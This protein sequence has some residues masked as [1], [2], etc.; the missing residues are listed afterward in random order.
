MI[1]A[2]LG[3]LFLGGSSGLE[4]FGVL[5]DTKKEVKEYVVEDTRRDAALDTVKAMKKRSNEYQ[6]TL[7]ATQKE[8]KQLFKSPTPSVEDL[9]A[10]W[11][12]HFADRNAAAEDLVRLRFELKEN[13]TRE[14]WAQIFPMP[15]G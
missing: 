4:I 15:E 3:I 6:D 12:R 1:V 8:L 13:I 2:L 7:K 5:K 10:L 11:S 14:E 9:D